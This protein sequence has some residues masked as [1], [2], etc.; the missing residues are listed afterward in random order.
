MNDLPPELLLAACAPPLRTIAEDL[1]VLVAAAEPGCIERVRGGW[2]VIGY[3]VPVGHRTRF[4]AW[5]WAQPEHV[6]LGF[7]HGVLMADPERVLGG[8]GVTKLARWLTFEPGDRVDAAIVLPLVHEAARVASLSRG[9][10]QI[11][12]RMARDGP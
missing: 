1:R 6:H 9:E 4:F 2:G 12:L 3:D 10:H 7:V 5:I 8:V 11:A